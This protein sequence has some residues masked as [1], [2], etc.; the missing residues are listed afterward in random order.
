MK[1]TR[2]FFGLMMVLFLLGARAMASGLPIT[3][4]MR[5]DSSGLYPEYAVLPDVTYEFCAADIS[6]PEQLQQQAEAG[7]ADMVEEILDEFYGMYGDDL[8][9]LDYYCKSCTITWE[10]DGARQ[11]GDDLF[12]LTPERWY[13]YEVKAKLHLVFGS[14]PYTLENQ[15]DVIY[16]ELDY[17]CTKTAAMLYTAPTENFTELICCWDY[18][19][20]A[21][22]MPQLQEN[23]EKFKTVFGGQ[24]P[25][26]IEMVCVND[27]SQKLPNQA[28]RNFNTHETQRGPMDTVFCYISGIGGADG[29]YLT[30]GG[31]Q[32]FMSYAELG[33]QISK[34][35][36]YSVVM[37]DLYKPDGAVDDA[38]RAAFDAAC[39]Q[40]AQAGKKVTV[41]GCLSDAGGCANAHLHWEP[42]HTDRRYDPEE[43]DHVYTAFPASLWRT[44]N[45]ADRDL[46]A[47][48]IAEG[49]G[50]EMESFA[51]AFGFRYQL[52]VCQSDSK[53]ENRGILSA[54]AT[55][56]PFSP[57]SE[58]APA[59]IRWSFVN[60]EDA[61]VCYAD[62]PT[63]VLNRSVALDDFFKI[64]VLPQDGSDFCHCYTCEIVSGSEAA[65]LRE[66][67]GRLWIVQRAA[68]ECTL[69]LQSAFNRNVFTE[70][71]IAFAAA[72][73][74]IALDPNVMIL[75]DENR[76]GTL[77]VLPEPPSAWAE[78]DILSSNPQTASVSAAS[79]SVV[80]VTA[81]DV[82]GTSEIRVKSRLDE[83]VGSACLVL[84]VPDGEYE[85]VGEYAYVLNHGG[86]G[87]LARLRTDREMEAI[88][89]LAPENV[90][91]FG[92]PD[93]EPAIAQ[94]GARAGDGNGVLRVLNAGGGVRRI[95][96]GA[97][98]G[99]S[100]LEYALVPANVTSIGEGAFP[101]NVC[102]AGDAGS[103]AEAYAQA[104]G[105]RFETAGVEIDAA[106]VPPILIAGDAVRIGY[107]MSPE[108][109]GELGLAWSVSD[110]SILTVDESG[111]L[112]AHGAGDAV[113][114]LRAAGIYTA[115]LTVHIAARDEINSV[116]LPDAAL[117]VE[118]SAFDNSGV[119]Y[120]VL[121]DRIES[122]GAR[123]FADCADLKRIELPTSVC[124][125]ADNAFEGSASV[126]FVC[127]AGS[128]AEAYAIE[129]GIQIVWRG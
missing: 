53:M 95:Q 46:T 105:M 32:K 104:H 100:A 31:T 76:A 98:S 51:D 102:L 115:E 92:D 79:Q 122:I 127:D 59:E 36:C 65:E 113:I 110:E 96:S 64:S 91:R 17:F 6:E 2:L 123:A 13:G 1:R 63:V 4:D 107:R 7:A 128:C 56:A 61:E 101:A 108:W 12:S 54:E 109:I 35:H 34:L 87:I 58:S 21:N 77:T 71:P 57:L 75:T 99:C 111:M 27:D 114:T 42:D 60:P 24:R 124:R 33:A 62:P 67:D 39:A 81:G 41:I 37:L 47:S 117:R 44:V 120:V 86:E 73:T 50:S 14:T 18:P 49:V 29:F 90:I 93:G 26:D 69:R 116:C 97:L 10:V 40:L 83:S 78:Y 72:P 103:A 15:N 5:Y 118:E 43:F 9:G 129:H 28:F 88:D 89:A 70:I 52:S 74:D 48:M 112:T 19:N 126:F 80:Q 125:I 20:Q 3:E 25:G 23:A 11:L 66:I 82:Y 84:Y 38:Q 55:A 68:G 121:N 45:G 16:H 22:D 106:S 85:A 30:N 8:Q 94:I 119:E